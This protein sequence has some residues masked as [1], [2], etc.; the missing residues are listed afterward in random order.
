[1]QIRIHFFY[2]CVIL[3]K[4]T[5]KD[6]VMKRF[7][8][9]FLLIFTLF[10][11]GGIVGC[12]FD[13]SCSIRVESPEHATIIADKTKVEKG[14]YISIDIECEQG[15]ILD[16]VLINGK[17]LDENK[18]WNRY[19]VTTDITISCVLRLEEFEIFY[20]NIED[21]DFNK[22]KTTFTV[23]D[24]SFQLE[25]PVRV[26]ADF[27]G[28][29]IDDQKVTSI[30]P[31]QYANNIN[32]F[33]SW[34]EHFNAGITRDSH[35]GEYFSTIYSLTDYGRTLKN[36]E[37]PDIVK[38]KPVKTITALKVADSDEINIENL[39][40]NKYITDLPDEVWASLKNVS[41][42]S[43]N[44]GLIQEGDFIY[45]VSGNEKIL[46]FI[47][48]D[49]F[50]DYDGTLDIEDDV[51]GVEIFYQPDAI[52]KIKRFYVSNENQALTVKTSDN[53]AFVEDEAGYTQGNVLYSSDGIIRYIG[54]GEE[55]FTVSSSVN[56]VYDYAFKNN[57]NLRE[58]IFEVDEIVNG[59]DTTYQ[60]TK[61][62]NRNAFEGCKFIKEI[63]VPKTLKRIDHYAFK[64][65]HDLAD[66]SSLIQSKL[67]YLGVEVFAH[68]NLY[69]VHLPKTMT[70]RGNFYKQN[71][72]SAFKNSKI[73]RVSP[74][75]L[76]ESD[77]DN[78]LQG[79]RY[80]QSGKIIIDGDFVFLESPEGDFKLIAYTG[81]DE[82]I[83]LPESIYVGGGWDERNR[84]V[85]Y[86]VDSYFLYYN[87]YVKNVYLKAS[88]YT[89]HVKTINS[90]AFHNCD[91]L[92]SLMLYEGATVSSYAVN[93]C[94]NLETVYVYRFY[95]TLK[96]TLSAG[97]NTNGKEI[98]FIDYGIEYKGTDVWYK[99]SDGN[100]KIVT[101]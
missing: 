34:K 49:Y 36:L 4:S 75:L 13:N 44:E 70:G 46:R 48:D 94:N 42:D 92:E 85:D 69:I 6:V 23:A 8:Y 82:T 54:Y 84:Y 30:D 31:S 22:T 52:S 98:K 51:T 95:E 72:A 58:I 3:N 28:W 35:T 19:K 76:L 2:L 86:T 64:D 65:C 99:D 83:V 93:E 38:G 66:I 9:A 53:Y 68:T 45:Y 100:V 41:L 26:G 101:E 74:S 33:A 60:G 20:K 80:G 59:E 96:P 78:I 43:E 7:I 50:T 27:E 37:I 55:S 17:K 25:D 73:V 11:A 91:K 12:G 88:G 24:N 16:C 71:V 87:Q 62:F 15:Y 21:A 57:V 67:D 90:N 89:S 1:M 5:D 81:T 56:R 10:F 47:N 97:W 29:Y 61:Y 39:K 79:T 18:S 40:L 14:E 32:V 63:N 77:I